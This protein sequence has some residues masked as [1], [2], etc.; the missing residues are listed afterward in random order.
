MKKRLK[1]LRMTHT[2]GLPVASAASMAVL[3]LDGVRILK[4]RRGELRME[5]SGR[6][7]TKG[8]I[9][10]VGVEEAT[11]AIASA[12]AD[13]SRSTASG[14]REDRV[15]SEKSDVVAAKGKVSE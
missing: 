13:L 9:E 8:R 11:G 12:M 2:S 15:V 7:L 1:I 6:V 3:K 4:V 5:N 10:T 14:F